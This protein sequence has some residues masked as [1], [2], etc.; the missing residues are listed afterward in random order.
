M[1]PR[2]LCF[3]RVHKFLVALF[4]VSDLTIAQ[5][6]LQLK[7][8]NQACGSLRDFWFVPVFHYYGQAKLN[9]GFGIIHDRL[10]RTEHFITNEADEQNPS[11]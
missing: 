9:R 11:P 1:M 2:R 4:H 6:Q 10:Q 8:S 3:H 5:P 7:D